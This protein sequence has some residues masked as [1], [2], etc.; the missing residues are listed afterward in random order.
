MC[1][2]QE[3]SYKHTFYEVIDTAVLSN[4][5][6]AISHLRKYFKVNDI[7]SPYGGL[8]NVRPPLAVQRPGS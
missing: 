7:N 3:Y 5:A 2:H 8:Y 1:S 4:F 6:K